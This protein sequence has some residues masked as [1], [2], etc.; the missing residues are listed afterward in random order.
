MG[1]CA[2]TVPKEWTVISVIADTGCLEYQFV[3]FPL[4]LS[5]PHFSTSVLLKND[6]AQEKAWETRIFAFFFIT[7]NCFTGMPASNP[8]SDLLHNQDPSI[9]FTV[10][11]FNKNNAT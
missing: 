9:P 8:L 11:W 10:L 4:L 3:K 1:P 5:M 6:E 7:K 2:V